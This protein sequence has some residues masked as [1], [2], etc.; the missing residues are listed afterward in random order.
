MAEIDLEALAD[1]VADLRRNAEALKGWFHSVSERQRE[2]IFWGRY[3]IERRAQDGLD[4]AF[5]LA[6]SCIKAME[7]MAT[8]LTALRARA[9]APDEGEVG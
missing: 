1:P 8:E 7:D 3:S 6:A 5:R 2:E 9:I 4:A